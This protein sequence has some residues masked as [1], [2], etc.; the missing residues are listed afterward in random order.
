MYLRV[1]LIALSCLLANLSLY[2][3]A[4]LLSTLPVR[5]E[6]DLSR[7][8]SICLIFALSQYKT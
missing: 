6:T 1:N 2:V 5:Q 7:L 4:V 8:I 3:W